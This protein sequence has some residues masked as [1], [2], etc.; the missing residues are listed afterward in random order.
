[1]PSHCPPDAKCQLEWHLSPTVTAPNRFGNLLQP[2]VPPPL[3]PPLSP[4]PSTASLVAPPPPLD[5][6]KRSPA[7]FPV[8]LSQVFDTEFAGVAGLF[9]GADRRVSHSLWEFMKNLPQTSSAPHALGIQ[10]LQWSFLLLAIVI[11]VLLLVVLLVLWLVPM[12][13]G[14]QHG[15]FITAEILNA[16]SGLEAFVMSIIGIASVPL[17]VRVQGHPYELLCYIFVKDSP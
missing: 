10:V 6:R 5:P 11:P 3:G 9:L 12:R 16:W 8:G 15:L 13:L 17:P 4:F 2:P 1:M 7:S 14:L